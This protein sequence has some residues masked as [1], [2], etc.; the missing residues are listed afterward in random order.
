MYFDEE[1]SVSATRQP[2]LTLKPITGSP[3]R[4]YRYLICFNG[5]QQYLKALENSF[6]VPDRREPTEIAAIHKKRTPGYECTPGR[7]VAPRLCFLGGSHWDVKKKIIGIAETYC[8]CW[9]LQTARG[10]T[11]V[12]A[13]SSRSDISTIKKLA[14]LI[15]GNRNFDPNRANDLISSAVKPQK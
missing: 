11:P 9:L 15:I 10:W 5:T 3:G 7:A 6:K 13:K 2:H 8:N 4:F 1:V 14:Y 12:T